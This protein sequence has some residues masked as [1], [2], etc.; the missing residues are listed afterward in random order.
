V[1]ND[2]V[3]VSASFEH[4]LFLRSDGSIVGWG[5][6]DYGQATPPVGNDFATVAAGGWHSLALK[7]DGS[8]VGWG[9]NSYGQAT[10][11]VGNDF[12]AVAAGNYHSLA[13]KTNGSIIG[14]GRNNCGQTTSPVGNDFVAVAAGGEHSLALRSDGSI[15]AWGRNDFGQATQ[16]AG[17]NFIAIAAG[18]LHSLALKSDGSIVGWGDNNYGQALPP[19]GNDFVD[20]TAGW[21]HS[22]AIKADGSILGW[23][24]DRCGQATPP[25]ENDFVAVAAG[26]GRSLAIIQINTP[27]VAV[28]GVDQ[29]VYAWIDGFADVNLDG[30][31]SYDDDGDPLTYLWSWQIVSDVYETNGV[32]PTIELPVGEHTI[33][34]VVNDGVEDSEPNYTTVTVIRPLEA[35]LRIMPRVINKKSHGRFIVAWLQLPP[36]ITKADI[37]N[38]YPL[39]MY[40]GGIEAIRK[41]IFNDTWRELPCISILAFFDRR[42]LL[43]AVEDDGPTWLDVTGR[44]KSGR[45]F[46]GQRRILIINRGHHN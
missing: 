27:P 23:G 35:E 3:S 41:L 16:A 14:W 22:L 38:D 29:T 37:D 5:R 21:F 10:S 30:S 42:K 32:N 26:E 39:T 6:N 31:G 18:N 43:D 40:P 46:Y 15:V 45:Y 19:S 13:L 4:S 24:D 9:W 25:V 17:N 28:A 1:G 7:S 34:L 8:I 12:M 36:K 11:P 20:I 44:L 2:F 33:E